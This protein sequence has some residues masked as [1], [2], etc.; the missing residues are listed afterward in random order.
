MTKDEFRIIVKT[1]KANY[2]EP[3]FLPDEDA[4]KIWMVSLADL[5]YK[6]AS[7]AAARCISTREEPPKVATIRKL[8]AELTR[9]A[10]DKL[11][12]QEAWYLVLQ[13]MRNSYYGAEKEFDALPELVKKAVGSPGNLREWGQTTGDSIMV[14]QSQFQRTYRQVMERSKED[15]AMPVIDTLKVIIGGEMK[16]IGTER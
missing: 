6:T 5:D 7:A 3:W 2:T 8:A 9:Q 16:Q 15:A 10:E 4:L 1:L 14:I 11:N 13:A 12:E